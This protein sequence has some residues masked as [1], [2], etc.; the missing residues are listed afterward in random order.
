MC[1][2]VELDP[3]QFY[4]IAQVIDYLVIV[5]NNRTEIARTNVGNKA[6]KADKPY[7]FDS[8]QLRLMTLFRFSDV[9]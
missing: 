2:S 1:V 6:I 4:T 7:D 3:S 8:N 5:A 9:L